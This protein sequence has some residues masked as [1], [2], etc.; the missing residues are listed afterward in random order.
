MKDLPPGKARYILRV[1]GRTPMRGDL[2]LPP[3][4][5]L[6]ITLAPPAGATLEGRILVDPPGDLK[7]HLRQFFVDGMEFT[8]TRIDGRG[9]FR[10]TGFPMDGKAHQIEIYTSPERAPAL[11]WWPLPG[12]PNLGP[13]QVR[14]PR[15]FLLKGKILLPGGEPASGR[16]L[17]LLGD[18]LT[19]LG[20]TPWVEITETGPSGT[21]KI[22]VPPGKERAV[23]LVLSPMGG[24]SG[25]VLTP[26]LQGKGSLDLGALRLPLGTRLAG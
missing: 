4:K 1:E 8:W 21:W 23:L 18:R 20:R 7:G 13:L 17:V 2:V 16:K 6:A 11:F 22:A 25:M 24:P 9:R 3:G 5:G 19:S 10:M 14:I 12:S 26:P 15:P